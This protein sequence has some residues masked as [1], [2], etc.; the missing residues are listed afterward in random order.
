MW[1]FGHTKLGD[2]LDPSRTPSTEAEYGDPLDVLH[3]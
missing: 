3:S 1:K 2:P